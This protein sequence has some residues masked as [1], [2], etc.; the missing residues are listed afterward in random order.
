MVLLRKSPLHMAV[1]LK[2]LINNSD[3]ASMVGGG[4]GEV[5][6][7]WIGDGGLGGGVFEVWDWR[8]GKR[9]SRLEVVFFCFFFTPFF[10]SSSFLLFFPFLFSFSI[11]FSPSLHPSLPLHHP[12][13]LLFPVVHHG[14][15]LFQAPRQQRP[16]HPASLG[17]RDLLGIP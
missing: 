7:W 1:F 3:P 15:G 10:F 9:V 12:P 14:G 11:F 4:L 17:L 16:Q 6:G 2:Y 8:V 13:P 5:W